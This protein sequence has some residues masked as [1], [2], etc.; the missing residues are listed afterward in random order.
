MDE[1]IGSEIDKLGNEINVHFCL[2]ENMTAKLTAFF[3]RQWA[4]LLESGFAT[5]NFIPSI[6]ACRVIYL[7]FNNEIIG[8][9][10][11]VW[12]QNT[13]RIILTAIDK[14]Y[15]R[16]GL[17]KLIVKYYDDRLIHANCIKSI[18]FIHVNNTAMME[19]ARQ[20]GYE[21]ELVKMVKK[22]QNE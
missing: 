10:I 1:L 3:A 12:E 18:T 17:L 15:R 6:N 4:E 22:Y 20:S 8:L 11:W 19:A 13:T 21:T 9:R 14:N 2:Y 16:R 5:S 7:T